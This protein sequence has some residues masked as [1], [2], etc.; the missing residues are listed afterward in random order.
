MES[1][2]TQR[3]LAHPRCTLQALD[4]ED[5]EQT[6]CDA[7][8]DD[9]ARKRLVRTDAEAFRLHMEFVHAHGIPKG[10][11][12][13]FSTVGAVVASDEGATLRRCR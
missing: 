1:H 4:P 12:T 3:V 9:D 5:L 6:M 2:P 11:V 7:V 10:E 8:H 13:T